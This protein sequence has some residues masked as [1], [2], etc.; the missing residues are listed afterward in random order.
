[1]KNSDPE[2][3]AEKSP[4]PLRRFAKVGLLILFAA[5]FLVYFYHNRKDFEALADVS[6]G[7][8]ALII[9]FQLLVI[10]TNAWILRS[11]LSLYGKR[12]PALEAFAVTLKSSIVNFFGFLQGG[13]GYKAIYLK[14][15]YDLSYKKFLLL[16]TANYVVIFATASLLA[17]CGLFIRVRQ[18]EAVDVISL[19]IF[20]G[21][22]TVML[23]IMLVRK[24]V[25]LR[26]SNKLVRGLNEALTGWHL[27]ARSRRTVLSL[28]LAAFLQALSLSALFYVELL[29]I[30]VDP[31]IPAA[32]LYAGLANVALLVAITPASLGFREGILILS[33][34]SLGLSTS[35]ILVSSTLE[36]VSYF[37][38]LA[39]GGVLIQDSVLRRLL[40]KRTNG[41]S[42]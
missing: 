13:I 17:L 42:L 10:V 7:H 40:P 32:L 3:P 37:L 29:A 26:G 15:N 28:L 18:G 9:L 19:L 34:T 11:L 33:Q 5:V 8:V 23:S 4:S 27:I 25:T 16:Y 21:M 6:A 12:M 1:M 31:T 2:A 22:A 20:G 41:K 39:V 38:L 24:Q 14:R 35:L 36:R 30:G